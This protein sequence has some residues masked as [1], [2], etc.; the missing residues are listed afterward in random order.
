MLLSYIYSRTDIQ[1][2]KHHISFKVG[3]CWK[4]SKDPKGPALLVWSHF[5][6]Y[7]VIFKEGLSFKK[8]KKIQLCH[9]P[10]FNL[11]Q[12]MFFKQIELQEIKKV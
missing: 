5:L 6:F 11:H 8:L 1:S 7:L 12:N 2:L 4:S 3:H 9:R 10:T